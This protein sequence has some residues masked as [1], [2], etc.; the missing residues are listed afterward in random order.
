MD[1]HNLQEQ[2]QEI[3]FALGSAMT[4]SAA[5]R[6]GKKDVAC[7]PGNGTSVGIAVGVGGCA[8]RAFHPACKSTA[9]GSALGL[10]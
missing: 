10:C 9:Q 7:Q 4:R 3:Q 2:L 8:G 1:H 5:N 6:V